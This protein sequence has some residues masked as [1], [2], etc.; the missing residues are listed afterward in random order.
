MKYDKYKS[1]AEVIEAIR[2]D[3]PEIR[4]AKQAEKYLRTIL[5][6]ES[7]Y[8]TRIIKHI[9]KLR[10]DAFVWK[11]ASGEYSRGGIPDI[12]AIIDGNYYGF[13]VKRPFIGEV[14]DLQRKTIEAIRRAGG[15]AC[16]VCCPAEAEDFL[17][18]GGAVT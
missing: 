3:H 17:K 12:C 16:V 18:E 13:E 1:K 6:L 14:T 9:K 5:P 10:P 7:H 2:K 8:Q 4:T 15:R 11:V